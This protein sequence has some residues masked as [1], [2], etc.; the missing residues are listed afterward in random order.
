LQALLIINERPDW[1]EL[2][3]VSERHLFSQVGARICHIVGCIAAPAA[4]ASRSMGKRYP[5]TID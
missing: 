5:F 2:T 3:F 1:M 4:A